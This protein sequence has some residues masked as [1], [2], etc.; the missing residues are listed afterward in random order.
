MPM[1]LAYLSGS[2]PPLVSAAEDALLV[3]SDAFVSLCDR[4]WAGCVWLARRLWMGVKAIAIALLLVSPIAMMMA[5]GALHDFGLRSRIEREG[6]PFADDTD[7]HRLPG[8]REREMHDRYCSRG[9]AH[10]R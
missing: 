4:L 6:C 10:W 8:A 7:L 9:T 2:C 5:A 3:A 1:R